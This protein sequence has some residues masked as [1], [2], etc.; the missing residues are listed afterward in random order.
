MIRTLIKNFIYAFGAQVV[1]LSASLA[2]TFI[3]PSLIGVSE[4]A[5]WQLFLT[6]V[7]YINIS[8][9]GL[10]DGLY[11]RLGGKKYE[12]LNYDLLSQERRYFI[13]FQLL[14][15]IGVLVSIL[16]LN[17][18]GDRTFVL[19]AC[20][21]CIVIINANNYLGY[22]LQ[23]VNLTRIYSVS[24][25]LQNLTWFVA[26]FC[27]LFVR[28]YSY[29][30]IV[31]LYVIG[32]LCAGIYLMWNAREIIK[33]R[34]FNRKAV[35]QDI[36]ENVRCG[37]KLMV[38]AYAGNLIIGST[39]MIIDASWGIEIFGFFSFSLTLANVFLTFVQQVSIVVFPALRRVEKERQK[40]AYYLLRNILSLV[41]PI[42]M[43]G[44]FPITIIVHYLMPQYE[45]SL[46]YLPIFLPICTFD[47][48][49]QMV[50]SSFF[51][52][53]RKES[54]LLLINLITLASSIFMTV[55]GAVVVDSIEFVAYGLLVIVAMRSIISEYIL[56]RFMS[57]SI[58]KE[59]IQEIG[60]VLAF[61]IFSRHLSSQYMFIVF[62]LI[63]AVYIIGNKDRIRK[64]VK[65]CKFFK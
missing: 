8:R 17:L 27:I 49:M 40:D 14:V 2:V 57:V 11:L 10:M 3:V 25:I 58:K 6:Y 29:K 21:V 46:F 32:H 37:I 4:F 35:F 34:R 13:G 19:L 54:T 64:V 53:M 26:V 45:Q 55:L 20:C 30:V 44:Y 24:I 47:G 15:A 23:A 18:E 38:A 33:H 28:I 50:C 7:T 59:L 5:Y 52:S 36:K 48:K 9:L 65:V 41:L 12:E 60:I 56:S 61:I 62:G 51:E 31:V 16:T 1:S 39:R 43:L 63:Y 22:I 42:V